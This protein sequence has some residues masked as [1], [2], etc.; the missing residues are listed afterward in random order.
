MVNLRVQRKG[1][2]LVGK[3]VSVRK[4]SLKL[5][6]GNEKSFLSFLMGN[7]FLPKKVYSWW[8][9]NI[10]GGER[11]GSFFHEKNSLWLGGA[12]LE[13]FETQF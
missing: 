10:P 8:Q 5:P 11:E 4:V 6:G 1:S 7:I 12:G 9:T 13:I 3:H 2:F